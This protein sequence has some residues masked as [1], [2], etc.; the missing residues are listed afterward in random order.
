MSASDQFAAL[1]RT[2]TTRRFAP[3]FDVLGG[4]RRVLVYLLLIV[5]AFVSVF[6]FFWMIVS[7]TNTAADIIKGKAT[8]GDALWVNIVNFF[9]QVDAPRIFWNS[10]FWPSS[11]PS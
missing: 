2:V 3:S 6:P 9:T 10:A 5:A 4:A 8:F 1:G 11:A 7:S